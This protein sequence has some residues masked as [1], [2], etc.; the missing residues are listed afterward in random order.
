MRH[1]DMRI[2][3]MFNFKNDEQI[4]TQEIKERKKRKYEKEKR[5]QKSN[6][7][8]LL[9]ENERFPNVYLKRFILLV[10]TIQCYC[11]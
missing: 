11:C 4:L 6:E 5:L 2:N 8:V 3:R 9:T 7:N 10:N 1:T